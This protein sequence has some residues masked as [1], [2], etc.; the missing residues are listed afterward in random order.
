MK[1]IVKYIIKNKNNKVVRIVESEKEA[2]ELVAR[3][4]QRGWGW[5]IKKEVFEVN[6]KPLEWWEAE[7][8][9][10]NPEKVEWNEEF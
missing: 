6:E 3:A 4:A 8:L 9:H 1:N 10:Q 5:Q 7:G 2:N